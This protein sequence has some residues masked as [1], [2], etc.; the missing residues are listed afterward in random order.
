MSVCC[1]PTKVCTS[2]RSLPTKSAAS[3]LPRTKRAL[4]STIWPTL[5]KLGRSAPLAMVVR[6]A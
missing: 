3:R 2:P 5:S 6:F 4:S 1:I